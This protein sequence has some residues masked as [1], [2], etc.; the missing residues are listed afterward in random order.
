MSDISSSEQAFKSRTD[1]SRYGNNART[2]FA[3]Q[4]KFQIEDIDLVASECLTDGTDDKKCDLIY[5]NS[6]EGYAV[7][8]QSYEAENPK[9]KEAPANKASDL[10]TAISWLLNT[11]WNELPERI[12]SAAE[13]L[14]NAI[15]TDHVLHIYIW[16]VHNFNESSNVTKELENVEKTAHGLLGSNFPG[17]TIEI[18]ALEIGRSKLQEWHEALSAPILIP[19]EISFEISG[20]YETIGSDWKAFL[21]SIP[22]KKLYELF[23]DH[24]TKLFSAN[25]RDYLGSLENDKNINYNI[26]RTAE[27]DP[28]NFWIY[29]NGLTALVND[30][31]SQSENGKTK[32]T[33]TG[34][35][36][37]NGAQTTGA[38]GSLEQLP[39]DEAY[40][41]IR[42]VKC[43]KED[44]VLNIIRY[45][46]S[47]NKVKASDF[48]SN[49]A[50]QRRLR[51][52][53]WRIHDAE[54]Q[55]GRRGSAQDIIRRHSNLLSSDTVAQTIASFHGDPTDAYNH[56]SDLWENDSKY[57]SLFNDHTHAPHIV[58]A[59][60]LFRCIEDHKET[61]RNKS[62]EGTLIETEK[63]E[64]EFLRNRGAPFLLQ[65]AIAHS[66][67]N[68]V[69][70]QLPNKFALSFGWKV[71]PDEAKEIWKPILRITIPFC[72]HLKDAVPD[73][74]QDKG[75]VKNGLDTFRSYVATLTEIHADAFKSFSE[76]CSFT[77]GTS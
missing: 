29:N 1:L 38:I 43:Q 12:R 71:S 14:Q 6:D 50:V 10:N 65:A 25:I 57:S 17:K 41:P 39:K 28:G 23:Q 3:L 58:L 59:Y 2:L 60:S 45:N 34:I 76:K 26:K 5:V 42:F 37:V 66:L 30:Y 68:I 4:I 22:A 55:G 44:V 21:T 7:V 70:R 74:I 77:F 32:L 33:I 52:E 61:L 9:D 56:K 11:K 47:Q 53:F 62:N 46:N 63:I 15:S 13:Q 27:E 51:E 64:L 40:V 75:K 31:S 20:G 72:S 19:D 18:Q 16:Y 24:K 8:G 35:S 67:E 48:R 36:I 54:Y 69:S 73:S 49:D